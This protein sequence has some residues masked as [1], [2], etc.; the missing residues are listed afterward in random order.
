ML[1][2]FTL[3]AV[4]LAVL[5]SCA[6][7]PPPPETIFIPVVEAMFLEPVQR[8]IGDRHDF[9]VEISHGTVTITG[10]RGTS[11]NL[12][13]PA[14]IFGLPVIGISDNA[15]SGTRTILGRDAPP[16]QLAGVS[17]PDSITF[18]GESAFANNILSSVVIPDSVTFIGEGA[19]AN[20][21]LTRVEISDNLPRIGPRVFENN[22]LAN[23]NIPASVDYIGH[24]A[25]AGNSSHL[26]AKIPE[27]IV[28]IR[29]GAFDNDGMISRHDYPQAPV[30]YD[31][32][33]VIAIPAPIAPPE[34]I[35]PPA[36]E[37]AAV[38]QPEQIAVEELVEAYPEHIV[39]V[40]EYTAGI[41]PEYITGAFP[42]YT[43]GE[44]I[45]AADDDS[46]VLVMIPVPP[47]PPLPVGG[48]I[49]T[50][51]V[52]APPPAIPQPRFITPYDGNRL[53]DP[54]GD[55]IYRVQ[56]GSFS[57]M[58]FA[59]RAS[60]VLRLAE[61][62]P[63]IERHCD[64]YHRVVIPRISAAEVASHVQRL[65]VAGFGDLWI[66]LEP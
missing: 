21:R 66:R 47:Q 19:F 65:G 6:T 13:I 44:Y 48:F 10:Y 43:A 38:E 24:R 59:Q 45:F 20:N 4:A 30:A 2:K 53:P 49:T 52:A 31:E 50:P 3:L 61:F 7:P 26:R 15:L 12:Q 8:Y 14:N 58:A 37:R 46:V 33:T 64:R 23:V 32:P 34:V 1:R 9:E 35:P 60:D 22:Q 25:F 29:V 36:P 56:V 54:G 51:V 17:L 5:A 41:Y 39:E 16:V 62:S 18:I 63:E 55:G 11:T 40:Y 27:G 42:E 57:S 28:W